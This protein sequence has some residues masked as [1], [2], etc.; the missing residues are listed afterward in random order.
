MS[1]QGRKR[2]DDR[3]V[4]NGIVWKFRTGT[5]WTTARQSPSYGVPVQPAGKPASRTGRPGS[6]PGPHLPCPA[7]AGEPHRLPALPAIQALGRVVC[8]AEAVVGTSVDGARLLDGPPLPVA[9][10]AREQA[11]ALS[12]V[13]ALARVVAQ[14]V[15]AVSSRGNVPPDLHRGAVAA[16][17]ADPTAAPVKTLALREVVHLAVPPGGAGTARRSGGDA[18]GKCER[19]GGRGKDA[20]GSSE[21]EHGAGLLNLTNRALMGLC[22][23]FRSHRAGVAGNSVGPRPAER[24]QGA[25]GATASNGVSPLVRGRVPRKETHPRC[26]AEK[27]ERRVVPGIDQS[28]HLPWSPQARNPKARS[29]RIARLLV[30]GEH[31]YGDAMDTCPSAVLD[32]S[33]IRPRRCLQT[34]LSSGSW[35]G[36]TST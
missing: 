32:S 31:R 33:L 9:A 26:P 5:A 6:V 10:V 36:D 7:V 20:S 8:P 15:G 28:G 35:S 1:L 27:Y 24:T 2:M 12:T 23:C 11:R 30:F 3:T 34:I 17:G 29:A 19:G 14:L 13:E 21:L 22:R 4:L 18:A 25:P 16:P